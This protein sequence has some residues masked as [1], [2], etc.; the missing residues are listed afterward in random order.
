[1]VG[2]DFV[3]DHDDTADV[4]FLGPTGRDLTV[5]QAVIDTGQADFHMVIG[6][7]RRLRGGG[8]SGGS[9]LWCRGLNTLFCRFFQRF[10][11]FTAGFQRQ[12]DQF[13][14]A[15]VVVSCHERFHQHRNVNP[16]DDLIVLFIDGDA[17]G[18]VERAAAPGIHQ[19]QDATAGV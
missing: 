11:A 7:Q 8:F 4:G 2:G 9:T 18:R 16:G 10:H 1:M 6:T 12:R 13:V 17:A 15:R 19:E 3:A 14:E 5:D